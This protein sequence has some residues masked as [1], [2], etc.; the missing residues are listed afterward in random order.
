MSKTLNKYIRALGYADKTLLA[1]SGGSSVVSLCSFNTAVDTPV[2]I[3]SA[4]ISLVF[5]IS[6][7]I[8]KIFLK[9]MRR[10]KIIIE[11]LLYWP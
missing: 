2:A 8:I 10:E 4:S 1:L 7:G 6:S 9:T 3:V 5:L 11:R